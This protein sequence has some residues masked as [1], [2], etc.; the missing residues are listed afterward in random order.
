MDSAEIV[1][2]AGLLQSGVLVAL[3]AWYARKTAQLVRLTAN[4]DVLELTPI[5]AVHFCGT[6]VGSHIS[7]WIRVKNVS[8][9]TAFSV[10][11]SVIAKASPGSLERD[12]DAASQLSTLFASDELWIAPP[13]S[14]EGDPP[15]LSDLVRDFDTLDYKVTF[16][17]QHSSRELVME[18]QHILG[19]D[20]LLNIREVPRACLTMM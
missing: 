9:I 8:T 1:A 7:L 19:I 3:T 11:F 17:G 18:G 10:H 6:P 20:P 14:A 12:R 4:R 13:V 2:W 16:R 5:V 15:F